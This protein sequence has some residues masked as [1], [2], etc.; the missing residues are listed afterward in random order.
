MNKEGS[1]KPV[2]IV[3]IVSLLIAAL[4]NSLTVLK[5]GIHALLNPS[6]GALLGW[7]LTLGM[8]ILVLVLTGITTAIQK[9]TTDQ[10]TI[11]ELKQQ[12][13]D[14]NKKS[15]EFKHD[16]QKM[17]EMQKEVGPIAMKMM[18]LSLRSMAYTAI[19]LILFFRW[20]VDYFDA[21]GNP[22]FFG[23]LGWFVF[24]LIFSIVFSSILRK[25]FDV[26]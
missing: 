21:L 8:L 23:F 22:K 24:Y 11:K 26:A 14:I 25:V 20:F 18:K 12:Q 10:K 9:Y 19:P 6:A 1:F 13:K 4:W 5:S 7:N 3:M 2:A 17:L 16:P 15:R